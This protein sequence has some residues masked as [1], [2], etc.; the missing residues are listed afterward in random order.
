LVCKVGGQPIYVAFLP[1]GG[2]SISTI[3]TLYG[4]GDLA[5]T[6]STLESQ[7][8]PPSRVNVKNGYRIWTWENTNPLVDLRSYA[9]GV[10][11]TLKTPE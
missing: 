9:R 3:Q 6:R 10:A 4:D 7:M 1:E 2:D 11:V 8:G 5:T